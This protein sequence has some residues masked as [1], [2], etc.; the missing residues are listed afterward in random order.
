[1][2]QKSYLLR[3][4]SMT[5]ATELRTQASG[6]DRRIGHADVFAAARGRDWTAVENPQRKTAVAAGAS[7]RRAQG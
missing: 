2:R 4:R 1:M 7:E 6:G 3:G 5:A